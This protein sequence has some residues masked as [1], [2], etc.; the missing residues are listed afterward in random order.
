MKCWRRKKEESRFALGQIGGRVVPVVPGIVLSAF[1]K[2]TFCIEFVNL[3]LQILL[4]TF[5]L[6]MVI[7]IKLEKK[8]FCSTIEKIGTLPDSF[9]HCA[10]WQTF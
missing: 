4:F 3:F 2:L 1:S 7:K 6:P 9:G 10:L 8:L 5:E